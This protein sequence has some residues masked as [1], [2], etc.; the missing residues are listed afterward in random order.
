[1][2][3]FSADGVGKPTHTI[4]EVQKTL[5]I[6]FSVVQSKGSGSWRSAVYLNDLIFILVIFN[7]LFDDI[8]PFDNT[9]PWC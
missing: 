8:I 6:N 4:L 3:S 1:M 7:D 2:P 9:F 5:D